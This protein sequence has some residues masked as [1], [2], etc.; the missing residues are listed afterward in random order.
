MLTDQQI[1]AAAALNEQQKEEFTVLMRPLDSPFE[2]ESINVGNALDDP[3]LNAEEL[4]AEQLLQL[5]IAA[6]EERWSRVSASSDELFGKPSRRLLETRVKQ[7]LGSLDAEMIQDL[8][9]IRQASM[10]TVIEVE[11]PVDGKRVSSMTIPLPEMIRNV[12]QSALGDTLYW[13]CMQQFTRG[14]S[15]A[16]ISTLRNYRIQYPTGTLAFPSMMNEASIM[17]SQGNTAGATEVLKQADVEENPER[18]RAQ[19]WLKRLDSA[20]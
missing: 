8:Q 3:G 9:Q 19:W 14:D 17:I 16:A 11:V 2:R 6:L 4:S 15:G 1:A 7:I 13:I 18:H 20:K 5:R 10:Q 12:Q